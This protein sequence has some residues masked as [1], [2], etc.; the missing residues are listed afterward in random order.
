MDQTLANQTTI[1]A[2]IECAPSERDAACRR[3]AEAELGA[4]HPE[5]TLSSRIAAD[6]LDV[7]AHLT[8]DG[9]GTEATFA[10]ALELERRLAEL[11][12][13]GSTVR[14]EAVRR[15][16]SAEA[17]RHAIVEAAR[18]PRGDARRTL[19]VS[20][21][22]APPDDPVGALLALQIRARHAGIA[23]HLVEP[24]DDGSIEVELGCLARVDDHDV[25]SPTAA[26]AP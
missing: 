15:E 26:P 21:V 24:H 22:L 14:L 7:V 25:A 18:P 12:A 5:A 13:A 9:E 17:T 2:A 8:I 11:T 20:L 23:L 1:V 16:P 4:A 3:R 6:R 10:S 19:R